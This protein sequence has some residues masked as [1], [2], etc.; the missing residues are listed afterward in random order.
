MLTLCIDRRQTIRVSLRTALIIASGC[1]PAGGLAVAELQE[2]PGKID[3]VTVYRG[4]ALVT[5]I[6]TLGGPEGLREVVVSNLPEQIVPESLYAETTDGIEVRSV[7]YRTR[8]VEQDVREE[9]RKLDAQIR[10]AQDELTASQ[11]RSGLAAERKAYLDKLEQF[12]AATANVELTRGVLNGETLEKLSRFL[13]AERAGVAEEELKLGLE[14]R[15]LNERLEQLG[16][17]RQVLTAGSARTMREAVVFVNLLKAEGGE[18]RVRYLVNGASWSPSYNIRTAVDGA[19]ATV[20]YN[21]AIQQMSGEDWGDVAMT[22]STATPSLMAR[23]PSLTPLTVALAAPPG[24]QPVAGKGYAVQRSELFQKQ[25]EYNR[26]W[27]LNI[28]QT[29]GGGSREGGTDGQFPS[30]DTVQLGN[31]RLNEVASELQVLDVTAAER[32]QRVA[33]QPALPAATEGFSVTYSIAARTTLPS[34]ADRQLIQIASLPM[35]GEFY[36]VAAP[37]LTSYVYREASLVNDS[38]RVLLAG[39]VATYVGGEFV[40]HGELATVAAGQSFTVGL[41]IDSALRAGR[42]LI[43]KQERVQGGNRVVELEYRLLIENFG[44][45]PADVRLVDRLPVTKGS[46]IRV[47]LGKTSQEP[48]AGAGQVDTDRKQGML[49]WDVQ[50]P[51]QAA[52]TAALA[53]EYRFTLE[54]DKQML[55]AGMTGA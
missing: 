21:A 41:G 16:R 4:Q 46:E 35:K 8:P 17:E 32:P 28:G 11:R 14:Q 25:Q 6:V 22:L 12:T 33:G 3:A 50:A 19:A 45:A 36:R 18:L 44:A 23:G 27:V 7:R 42:E 15:G 20:E 40:G 26:E 52:G 48:R 5:R 47:T 49:R 31:M 55:I 43:D 10:A 30:V 34:R 39:P 37:V 2:T 24:E 53:V 9:V 51:A 13:F 54:Y 38:G 1:G 29:R